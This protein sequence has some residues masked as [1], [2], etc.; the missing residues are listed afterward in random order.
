MRVQ[1]DINVSVGI[2]GIAEWHGD[3]CRK[4]KWNFG[5]GVWKPYPKNLTMPNFG[6]L[7][8]LMVF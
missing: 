7:D 1:C 8:C 4:P 6:P 2:R 5:E 3:C